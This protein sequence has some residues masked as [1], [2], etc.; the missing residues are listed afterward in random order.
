MSG[1]LLVTESEATLGKHDHL[2]IG[3]LESDAKLIFRDVRKFG[4]FKFL[5]DRDQ[6]VLGRLGVEGPEITEKKLMKIL[7]TSKRPIKSFLL[8]QNQI[9]GLGNIY[10]D[11]SLYRA[12]IHPLTSSAA[13]L[14]QEA[15][16]L[17]V[18]IR[19]VL[20]EAIKHLG[21]TFD[22]FQN[23]NGESGK[24]SEYL[25]VYQQTGSHCSKCGGR[26]KRIKLAGRGT[27]FCP[28]CQKLSRRVHRRGK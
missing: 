9:A 5:D 22:S 13:I 14:P 20:R 15:Q 18:A 25:R 6:D 16:R 27:H 1:R 28:N 10:V 19:Y 4:V 8:D 3:F 23:V 26:I 2:S 24:H 7:K 17:A 12:G 11:E 21:T